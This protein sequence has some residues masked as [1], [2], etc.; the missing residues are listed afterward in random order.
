DVRKSGAPPAEQTAEKKA[1]SDHSD[2]GSSE[3]S[4]LKPD[5]ESDDQSSMSATV[6][7]EK[8]DESSRASEDKGAEQAP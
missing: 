1:S 7:G 6:A 4:D 3:H 8:R 2:P 5:S